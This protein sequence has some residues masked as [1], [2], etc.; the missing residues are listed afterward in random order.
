MG[1]KI[2]I[3]PKSKET[4]KQASREP[5]TQ[6]E[7]DPDWKDSRFHVKAIKRASADDIPNFMCNMHGLPIRLYLAAN[8]DVTRT[9][10]VYAS[11]WWIGNLLTAGH[12]HAA[13][14][15]T[16]PSD[17]SDLGCVPKF[18]PT[19]VNMGDGIDLLMKAADI[20]PNT[21]KAPNH[22]AKV[23]IRTQ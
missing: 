5:E 9:Y 1:F 8:D 11:G 15:V 21:P 12:E 16:V 4:L 6:L 23:K 14:K 7:I 17:Y 22:K 13:C 3:K 10:A 20:I 18:T 2:E 19:G